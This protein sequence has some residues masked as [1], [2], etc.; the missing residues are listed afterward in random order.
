MEDVLGHVD[1][2]AKHDR[3]CAREREP[4]KVGTLNA[5][6]NSKSLTKWPELSL[7]TTTALH[8]RNVNACHVNIE[9]GD[10]DLRALCE[11]P[12]ALR[13]CYSIHSRSGKQAVFVC[14]SSV[15]GYLRMRL[16]FCPP[17]D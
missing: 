10:R 5:R 3:K 6:L 4:S 2:K 1:E 8:I 15:I 7:S 9:C 12:I 17:M 13:S 16:S 14:H 11:G